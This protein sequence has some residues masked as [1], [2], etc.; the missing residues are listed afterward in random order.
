M[1]LEDTDIK[2]D[3]YYQTDGYNLVKVTFG[4]IGLYIN[5]FKVMPSPKFPE[6]GLWV[7]WP[8]FQ[9][10]GKWLCPVE[11]NRNSRLWKL[12]EAR[13]REAVDLYKHE[14][15]SPEELDGFDIKAELDKVWPDDTSI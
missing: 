3:V 8:K 10:G 12:V 2:A 5:S 15:M 1:H 11:F 9:V 6:K 4:H 13:C 14:L 7:Q